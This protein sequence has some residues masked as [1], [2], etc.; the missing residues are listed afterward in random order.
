MYKFDPAKN[1]DGCEWRVY[2]ACAQARKKRQEEVEKI[3]LEEQQRKQQVILKS[4]L[5]VSLISLNRNV[6]LRILSRL[7]DLLKWNKKKKK[8]N[9]DPEIA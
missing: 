5:H 3:R 9:T 2:M 6:P 4:L 8:K 7:C 1:N